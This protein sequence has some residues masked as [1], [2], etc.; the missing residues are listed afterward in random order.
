MMLLLLGFL[1]GTKE[2]TGLE[3]V[4]AAGPQHYFCGVSFSKMVAPHQEKIGGVFVGSL[5]S[6]LSCAKL[7]N[8]VFKHGI[9]KT[10]VGMF[11][12]TCRRTKHGL[13]E[14]KCY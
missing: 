4:G 13:L 5:L 14:Q 11:L 6:L 9:T 10:N 2:A 3:E 12:K 1:H 8:E 7:L